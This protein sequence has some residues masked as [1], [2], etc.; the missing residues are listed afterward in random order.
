MKKKKGQFKDSV[1]CTYEKE[2]SRKI[3]P[4]TWSKK[5]LKLKK[6]KKR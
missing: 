3:E 6:N 5:E 4:I 1:Y 2:K